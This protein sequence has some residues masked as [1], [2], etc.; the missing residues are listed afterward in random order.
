M[1]AENK[2]MLYEKVLEIAENVTSILHNI[3][4]IKQDNVTLKKKVGKNSKDI[5]YLKKTIN[6][7]NKRIDSLDGDVT[8]IKSSINKFDKL[9][10]KLF[11]IKKI[12]TFIAFDNKYAKVVL[13]GLVWF[14]LIAG[15]LI[16][17]YN[18]IFLFN[19]DKKVV[20]D[21]IDIIK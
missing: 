4:T 1:S 6:N 11:R 12:A 9:D 21:I 2:E 13:G 3:E 18:L 10:Y 5:A 7:H 14:I 16:I 8:S 15:A 19:I 20:E 17:L